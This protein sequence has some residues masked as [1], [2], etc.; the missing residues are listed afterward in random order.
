[1]SRNAAR[2]TK[3]LANPKLAAAGA[4]L[5]STAAA[6]LTAAP[7]GLARLIGR[8]YPTIAVTGMTGVG[9]TALIDRLTKRSPTEGAEVG[10]AT[11]EKR[12]R[13]R[14]RGHG[15]RF[16]VVPGDNAATRLGA[17]D[18]VFHDDPVAGVVHV[19]ANGYATPRRV[20]GICVPSL[21]LPNCR[22]TSCR[23]ARRPRTNAAPHTSPGSRLGWDSSA[24]TSD[25][26]LC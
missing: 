11:M 14:V 12:T 7:D 18:A 24:G 25:L 19:V 21:A 1:M 5:A 6:A 23:S 13:R 15:F 2:V 22:S 3:A 9:K 17:L 16:R 10:S 8:R 4:G 26:R 20:A